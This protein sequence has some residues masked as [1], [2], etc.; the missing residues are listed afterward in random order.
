M[1]NR[2]EWYLGEINIEEKGLFGIG[3]LN[4]ILL[5]RIG[6][7]VDI[8]NSLCYPFH[9]SL[10][11][12]NRNEIDDKYQIKNPNYLCFSETKLQWCVLMK[13]THTNAYIRFVFPFLSGDMGPQS[14]SRVFD[15][16]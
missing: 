10:S 3:D 2:K 8:V 16:G 4:A 14:E 9:S 12:S 7:D 6:R 13:S 1:N 5:K 11:L 15:V